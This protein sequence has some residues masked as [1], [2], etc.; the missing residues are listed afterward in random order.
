MTDLPKLYIL[1]VGHGN[2]AVLIDKKGTIVVDAG[3]DRNA[4]ILMEFI[5]HLKTKRITTVIISHGDE[6]HIAGLMSLLLDKNIPVGQVYLNPDV[7]RNTK[8]WNELRVAVR[9]AREQ[10]NTAT[11][12]EITSS[13]TGYFDCGSVHVQVVAPLPEIAMSGSGGKDIEGRKLTSNAMSAIIRLC[14]KNNP[15]VLLPGDIES[16]GIDNLY[17]EQ[18]DLLAKV[19]VF[20]HHGGK[21]A[22][23][24]M[25]EFTK[26]IC[27]KT[28]ADYIIFSNGRGQ[29]GNP[30]KEIIDIIKKEL[31]KCHILCTQISETCSDALPSIKHPNL[32]P[33]AGVCSNS[34]CAGTIEIDLSGKSLLVTP[35]KKSHHKFIKKHIKKPLCLS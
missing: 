26:L 30:R 1:D 32:L 15:L 17:N 24:N 18:Q 21:P 4:S 5:E 31:P 33:S 10:K 20:P 27:R 29:F 7:N 3:K 19:L 13:L 8:I 6:D 16:I 14:K 11:H 12:T 22:S 23:M 34:C 2:S 9:I 25:S 28:K 35:E